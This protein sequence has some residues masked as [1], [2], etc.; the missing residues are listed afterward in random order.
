[1]SL[2][3]SREAL[4]K[5]LHDRSTNGE[6]EDADCLKA[7]IWQRHADALIASGAVRDVA[8]LADDD[9]LVER[10]ARLS[11]PWLWRDSVRTVVGKPLEDV[12]ASQLDGCRHWL[13]T[14]AAALSEGVDQ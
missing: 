4:A 1:V 3:A 10:W 7:P 12:R 8:S 9:A 6:C 13:R 5:A 2:V 14:L 11:S